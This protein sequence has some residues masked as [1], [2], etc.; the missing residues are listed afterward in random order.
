MRALRIFHSVVVNVAAAVGAVA[1]AAVVACL[2]LGVRPAIVISGS[3]APGIPVGAMTFAR[4][5]PA[6]DIEIGDVVSLQRPDGS[7]LVTHRVVANE[8]A[9]GIGRTLTLQGDANRAP[10]LQ[11]YLAIRVGR[12]VFTVPYLGSI[13][14]WMQHHV[15][16]AVGLV[17]IVGGFASLPIRRSAAAGAPASARSR[18]SRRTPASPGTS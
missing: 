1:I 17:V 18:A 15:L 12:V 6:P 7:G 11:P 16:L 3:M 13:A 4:T 5:V 9:P 14:L 8:P 10:D 2:V